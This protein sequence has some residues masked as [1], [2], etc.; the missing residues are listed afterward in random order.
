M[1]GQTPHTA[2]NAKCAILERLRLSVLNGQIEEAEAAARQAVQSG[3]DPLNAIEE[4]LA[5]GIREVGEKFEKLELFLSDMILAGDAMA[6]GISILETAL[7]GK[8]MRPGSNA[9]VIGTVAGDIHDIGKTIVANLLKAN[10]FAIHDL[11]KDV[12]SRKFADA[13]QAVNAR[14]IGLSALLSTTMVAQQDVITILKDLELRDKYMV[15]VGGA[16]VT[17]EWA[18][19]IGA[20]AY[21]KDVNDGVAKVRVFLKNKQEL[22]M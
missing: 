6:R 2:P 3:V 5:K 14:V 15:I 7:P 9:I 22:R 1:S 18:S 17:Q 16:P 11:G 20:D 10:G 8:D 4:G 21:G 19:Q 12:P 13:A